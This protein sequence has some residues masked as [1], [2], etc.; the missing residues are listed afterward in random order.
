M[1]P[2]VDARRCGASESSG[3]GSLTNSGAACFLRRV[4]RPSM[5]EADRLRR[6][7]IIA[8]CLLEVGYRVRAKATH[9]PPAPGARNMLR[10]VCGKP[11]AIA[12]VRRSLL[13]QLGDITRA[14]IDHLIAVASHEGNAPKD[15]PTFRLEWD[16]C[17]QGQIPAL[18][19]CWR[20][21][22]APTRTTSQCS[23]ARLT[24]CRKFPKSTRFCT[25]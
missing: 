15:L 4:L 19:P 5:P 18:Q 25:L 8:E 21:L 12:P 20:W 22:S 10:I 6:R 7:W 11:E 9:V 17:L 3:T 24:T 23:G 2:S 16:R 13:K 1:C 14:S